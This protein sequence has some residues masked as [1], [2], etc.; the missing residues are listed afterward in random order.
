MKYPEISNYLNKIILGQE[1]SQGLYDPMPLKE[2]EEQG[3]PFAM[4]C[5]TLNETSII[6]MGTG[7]KSPADFFDH[8]ISTR[9]ILD[10]SQHPRKIFSKVV[11]YL[12]EYSEFK[13]DEHIWGRVTINGFKENGLICAGTM[14]GYFSPA[15]ISIVIT[16]TKEKLRE[17]R[18]SIQSNN[19]ICDFEKKEFGSFFLQVDFLRNPKG[20]PD[21]FDETTFK[22]SGFTY[23]EVVN[24][25]QQ[26]FNQ[27][28]NKN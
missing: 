6:A 15:M 23:D 3:R 19:S 11:Y 2:L 27:L 8:N 13:E 4:S 24:C 28:R 12:Q 16:E 17:A 18:E 25:L 5:L 20:D 7:M 14:G 10:A 26:I 1:L 21:G 22:T 9:F